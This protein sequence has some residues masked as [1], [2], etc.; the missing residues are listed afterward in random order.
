[1]K[2]YPLYTGGRTPLSFPQPSTSTMTEGVKFYCLNAT[3]L[4][5][6]SGRVCPFKNEAMLMAH[7]VYSTGGMH[8][9]SACVQEGGIVV[10]SKL[11]LVV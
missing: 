7:S 2:G 11:Y 8:R 10:F 1:M 9:L 5:S 6:L 4:N 3:T